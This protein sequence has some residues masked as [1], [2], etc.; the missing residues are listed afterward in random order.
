MNAAI[1]QLSWRNIRANTTRLLLSLIAVVLGTGFVAGGFIL[2]ATLNKAF[3]DIISNNYEG[4]DVVVKGSMEHPLDRITTKET[5]EKLPEVELAE[6]SGTQAVALLIDD[7][8][9]QARGGGTWILPFTPDGE[10]IGFSELTMVEG[11]AP[12]E[13]G[14]GVINAS[15]AEQYDVQVGDTVAV[16]DRTGRHEFTIDGIYDPGFDAGNWAGLQIP[17]D[18]YW[19]EYSVDNIANVVSVRAAEGT[20]PEAAVDAIST[21]LPDAEVKTGEQATEDESAAVREQLAFISYILAAFGLIALLV[22]SFI[23]SNTFSMIVAQRQKEYALLRALGMSQH[24]LT[25]SV[26][27]EA[28]IIGLIGSVLGIGVGFGLIALI[29]WGMERAEVGFPNAGIGLNWQAVVIS[30]VVGLLVT[31][32]GAWAP[33]RR[34]GAVRPVE[35]MRSGETS[36]AQPLRART[37][38][39]AVLMLAGIGATAAGAFVDASTANRAM[40]VGVGALAMVAGWLLLSAAI[41][42]V[43]SG[44]TP[45]SWPPVGVL[46]GTNLA[47]N[48]RRTASTAFALMLGVTLVSAVGILGASMKN[49]V[50]GVVDEQ[51]RADAVIT[52]SAPSLEFPANAMEEIR[53]MPEVTGSFDSLAAP[54]AVIRPG[55]TPEQT[56]EAASGNGF[57]AIISSDPTDV[58]NLEVAEGDFADLVN[59]PGVGMSRSEADKFGVSL[60]DTVQVVSPVSPELIDEPLAVIWEDSDVFMGVGI[61]A[62]TARKLVPNEDQ[63]MRVNAMVTFREDMDEQE[64]IAKL[65]ETVKPFAVLQ[66]QDRYEFRDQSAGQI[67]GLL[68]VVYG[69]LALSVVIAI[70]G[71]INTLALSITERRREFGTLR[72]VGMQRAQVRRMIAME[73]VVIAVLGA[74][75]GIVL[76]TWVGYAFVQTLSDTGLDRTL[77][78]WAQLGGVLAVAVVVGIVAALVPSRQAARTHPLAATG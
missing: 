64:G 27:V 20:S 56:A 46:A 28:F 54:V 13:S 75:A 76:G 47:R 33:A 53:A 12:D 23:I 42:R 45:R 24:Q 37:V 55:S 3:E 6:P 4:V 73:S 40:L 39:G 31:L 68:S 30:L 18:Q 51:L 34:A 26:A 60:G 67:D 17:Q 74:L 35:A 63:W 38:I 32:W 10:R 58:I 29:V 16:V 22:G 49:S 65:E 62:H 19:D 50:F 48:P 78:P 8:P 9:V 66:V 1:A 52:K 43:I 21:A 41:V 61:S 14:H 59:G 15:T 36:T 70:F 69:L 57:D 2:T 77:I 44:A 5:L 25:G 7:T 71:I 11:D 72:A